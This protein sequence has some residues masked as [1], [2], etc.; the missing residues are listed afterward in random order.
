MPYYLI[1]VAYTPEAW[2]AQLKNP[3]DRTT[4]VR[5]MMERV[6]GRLE[7]LYYAFGE[8]DVFVTI[9]VPDNV[10]A[11]AVA[12]AVGSSGAFKTVKTTPLMTVEEGLS[13]MRKGAGV[14]YQPP[15]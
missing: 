5:P 13:A 11:A 15:T 10:S 12:L 4:V 7:S 2:A 8:Y 14:A 6:G 1:Q 9:E 3:Q